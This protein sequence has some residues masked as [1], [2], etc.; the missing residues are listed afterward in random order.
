MR[1]APPTRASSP[2]R[3]E[4]GGPP[5]SAANVR[6]AS[7]NDR[8][9]RPRIGI[10][11]DGL[12]ALACAHYAL[13]VELQPVVFASQRGGTGRGVIG[14][15]MAGRFNQDTTGFDRFHIPIAS[16]DSALCGL[17]ADLGLLHRVSWRET[18]SG[19]IHPGYSRPVEGPAQRMYLRLHQFGRRLLAA[20][21][22]GLPARDPFVG[23]REPTCCRAIGS[24]TRGSSEAIRGRCIVCGRARSASSAADSVLDLRRSSRT[25]CGYLHGGYRTLHDT[26]VTSILTHGGEVIQSAGI[27][28]VEVDSC[29]ALVE[30]DT[31]SHRLD[32]LVSTLSLPTLAKLA[33]GSM[34]R[35]LPFPESDASSES[36]VVLLA[37]TLP[38]LPYVTWISDPRAPFS[39]VYNAARVVPSAALG[40]YFPLY[41]T[42]LK[43]IGGREAPYTNAQLRQL[44]LEEFAHVCPMERQPDADEVRVFRT[45]ATDLTWSREMLRVPPPRQ[46]G[47]SRLLLCTASRALPRRRSLDTSVML[48]RE[49]TSDLRSAF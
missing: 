13:R 16:T 25:R 41:F 23:E 3:A 36:S 34:L 14:D 5:L 15:W 8:A 39:C 37:R 30:S 22:A 47:N 18:D 9:L 33:R 21:S 44:A 12:A 38:A 29:G 48:A 31:G 6:R 11:G 27:Q 24:H 4:S 17:L 7:A 1:S 2:I 42:G 26:L 10:L 19:I 28:A 43:R 35:A 32:A 46:V 45:E 49:T 40:G 20:A